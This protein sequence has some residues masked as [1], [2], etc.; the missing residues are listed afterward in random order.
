MLT[1]IASLFHVGVYQPLY[2]ALILLVDHMPLYDMGLAVIVLTL[3]VRVVL[4]PLS[5]KA[6]E[7]QR[8][9]KEVAPEVEK[10]KAKYKD[11]KKAQSEAIFA[12]YRE[13]EVKL[14]PG[15]I[16]IVIQLPILLALY[17]IFAS[18]GLP[19]VDASLLYTFV[20]PPPV[21]HTQFLGMIDLAGRSLLL[22]LL[23]VVTQMTYTRLA[24]GPRTLHLKP[25]G[26]SLGE[27]M[28]ASFDL[29]ARYVLP[30]F[31]GVFAYYVAA[32]APLFW[33]TSNIAMIAQE[34]WS[35]RRF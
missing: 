15:F 34:Y 27:D 2:N 11:D 23:V 21:I 14:S 30:L 31:F 22:A 19:T 8:K 18:S 25:K 35:G 12:L 33:V 16:L 4:Y 1:M 6:I 20:S 5:K 13:R 10:I 7:A 26:A 28:A 32:A 17:W 9:I 24:M 29:Q 3:G